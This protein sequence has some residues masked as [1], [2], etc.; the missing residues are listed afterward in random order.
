MSADQRQHAPAAERNAAPI[1]DA[2]RP[3]LPAAGTVLELASGSGQH[4]VHFAAA[5]P[6]LAWQPSDADPEALRSIRAWR[7]HAALANLREPLTL[8]V[9]RHPWPIVHADAI[10][11]ANLL[12]VAPAGIVDHLFRGAAA[13]LPAGGGVFLYGPFR[14]DGTHTATSNAEF[15]RALRRRNPAWGVRDL[16]DLRTAAATHGLH[17]RERVELPANNLLLVFSR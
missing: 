9:H 3:R 4:A 6:G 2:L 11:S 12:H 16:A 14:I 15:D 10:Y 1:L 8:D 5:L 7:T 13:V 17:Y